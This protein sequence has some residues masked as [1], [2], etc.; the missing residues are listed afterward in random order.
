MK[1]EKKQW[2]MGVFFKDIITMKYTNLGKS[3][4]HHMKSQVNRAMNEENT[5]EG[6]V[7]A[8]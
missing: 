5:I 2:Q 8:H 6:N 3:H 4:E 7:L 1:K